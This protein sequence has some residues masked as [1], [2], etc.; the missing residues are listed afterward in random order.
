M[1]RTIPKT[2]DCCGIA[3][4]AGSPIARWCNDRCSMR[5]FHRRRRGQPEADPGRAARTKAAQ[6]Q[7]MQPQ[8]LAAPAYQ[9]PT[10]AMVELEVESRSWQGTPIQRRQSDGWVNATAMCHAGGREWFTYA[11]NGRTQE[12]ITALA[13]ALG[14][15]QNCGHPFNGS[16]QEPATVVIR[17]I[18]TGPNDLRGTWIH[19]RLAVDL[20]RWISPAFAVWMD[21]WF[22]ETIAGRPPAAPAITPAA[23]GITVTARTEREAWGIWLAAIEAEALG[24]IRTQ[25]GVAGRP[26]SV[27]RK[28]ASAARWQFAP[29]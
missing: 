27:I 12:Y 13:G 15:P 21:G 25:L 2:C 11:R 16:P 10:R 1:T 5:A 19:P 18:T 14:S 9:A 22:L 24:A 17:S 3:F 7:V 29:C 4:M 8:L 6:A 28:Q 26:D 20:A 23:P